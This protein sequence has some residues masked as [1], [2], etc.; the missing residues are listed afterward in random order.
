MKKNKFEEL[1]KIITYNTMSIFI[2]SLLLVI[3]SR[4]VMYFLYCWNN[5]GATGDFVR[6]ICSIWDNGWYRG[7]IEQGYQ[8]EPTNH[9]KGDAANWA[10]FPLSPFLV[11]VV[12]KCVKLPIE[13]VAFCVNTFLLIMAIVVAMKYILITRK[14]AIIA[15][16]LAFLLAFGPYTFYCSCMY[17]ESLY[18]LLT[19]LCFYFLKEKKYVAMG[20]CGGL[21][22]ATRNTG[23][24]F[25]FAIAFECLMVELKKH[26][27]IFC[28]VKNILGNSKLVLGTSFVP[29]GLFS[30]MAYLRYVIGDSLAFV[31]IQKAWQQPR[32]N[33]LA[34]AL[35]YFQ[36]S[37]VRD[38][39][40]VILVILV[41]FL[42]GY[43]VKHGK[44]S[45]IVMAFLI[46]AIQS[47]SMYQGLPRYLFSCGMIGVGLLHYVNENWSKHKR[48]LAFI[49]VFIISVIF[50]KMWFDGDRL[51]I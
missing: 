47:T 4:C 33:P 32:T 24:F 2:F 14:S 31:R 20:I 7:I 41:L 28:A 39:Y 44:V 11:S 38:W 1:A 42:I 16:E 3:I 6:D 10:F 29:L 23:V 15:I 49:I 40:A 9:A 30:Y 22:S 36:S 8:L 43:Q 26:K 21:L 18:L 48:M 17:T 19:F 5:W 37:D 12:N 45:E 34:V 51:M 25:V 35:R 50:M 13:A 46:I 27:S